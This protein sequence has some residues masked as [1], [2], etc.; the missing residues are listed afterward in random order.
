MSSA[1][2]ALSTAWRHFRPRPDLHAGSRQL[3]A[4]LHD[5][6]NL[7]EALERAATALAK[8][9]VHD[10]AARFDGGALALVIVDVRDALRRQLVE[11]ASLVQDAPVSQALIGAAAAVDEEAFVGHLINAM[12]RATD[13]Y[14]EAHA[15]ERLDTGRC[16]RE[17]TALFERSLCVL[18]SR[19][20]GART[21]G[22]RPRRVTFIPLPQ[23]SRP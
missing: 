9:S 2:S 12:L 6:A 15:L 19:H 17:V 8:A 16:I 23:P 11:A 5:G 13:L 1:L 4:A 21:C 22:E 18:V 10:A 3:V 14:T 7:K 20:D